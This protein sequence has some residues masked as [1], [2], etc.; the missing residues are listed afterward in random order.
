MWRSILL[1]NL[2]LFVR[3]IIMKRYWRSS[4][5]V[6]VCAMA[7]DR[8]IK[9]SN[10]TES[11]RIQIKAVVWPPIN[12]RSLEN[13]RSEGKDILFLFQ[14]MKKPNLRWFLTT[15]TVFAS[16]S[17]SN[18]LFLVENQFL[19]LLQLVKII[20]NEFWTQKQKKLSKIWEDLDFWS[21]KIKIGCL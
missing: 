1:H 8:A 9:I 11:F 16:T 6:V 20:L 18:W 14:R 5:Y 4:T 15:F 17:N 7:S 10:P 13:P 3:T 2:Y 12:I 19:I 21:F